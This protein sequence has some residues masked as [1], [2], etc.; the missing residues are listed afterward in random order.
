MTEPATRP[1]VSPTV[2]RV[3][4]CALASVPETENVPAA[5]AAPPLEPVAR[6]ARIEVLDFVRG[7][8]LL[9]ILFVNLPAFDAPR[10]AVFRNEIYGWFPA[11]YDQAAI[12]LIRI[13]ATSKFY[14]IL[15]FLFGLGFG[16]QL[17]RAMER[18]T[19]R[20]DQYYRRR[21]A[22]LL[23]LGLV[24]L[25][26]VWMGDVLHVYA[27]VGFL[28]LP[29]RKRE[30]RTVLV[31]AL[32]LSVV[33]WIAGAAYVTGRALRETPAAQAERQR[34]RLEERAKLAREMREEVETYARGSR[35]EVLR[36]RATQGVNNAGVKVSWGLFEVWPTFL[37][38]LW[39]AR[40][41][42]LDDI[43]AHLPL[44][45]RLFWWGLVVGGGGTIGLAV[46]QA[47]MGTDAPP[48]LSFLHTLLG[49]LVARPFHALFYAAGLLLLVQSEAWR[50]R[51]APLAA[52]GRLALTNYLGQSLLCV[53][54]FYGVGLGLGGFG[55]FGQV[56]PALGL[57]LMG[58]IWAVLIA[59]SLWWSKRYRL[60]P[61]EWAWRS[62]AYGARQRM[63]LAGPHPPMA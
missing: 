20:F 13:V 60:G 16:V 5:A 24:H 50:R 42:I 31:W 22:L 28:L 57:A 3:P 21:L 48:P 52:V 19:E 45:R 44:F 12:W 2:D 40:R 1:H 7:F 59:F 61:V 46:W 41:R 54:L 33:P 18:G 47:R 6:A 38:G 25:L 15:S 8:A 34:T 49:H 51:L 56:G 36:L 55:Y 35:W 9:G 43:P 58:A 10:Y 63:R 26:L 4:E 27:L 29:F 37:L 17:T 11:W 23:G 62:L 30:Q 39:V 53:T 32:A 14:T